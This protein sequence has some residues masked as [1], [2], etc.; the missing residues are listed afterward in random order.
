MKYWQSSAIHLRQ[1]KMAENSLTTLTF[2]NTHL[3]ETFILIVSVVGRIMSGSDF[4][5]ILNF[6]K[7]EISQDLMVN[8]YFK[9]NH[10]HSSIGSLNIIGLFIL[11]SVRA[12]LLRL[13]AHFF[14][15]FR[16]AILS[17]SQYIIAWQHKNIWETQFSLNR[18]SMVHF[19]HI[20]FS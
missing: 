15:W 1:F 8:K 5:V 6:G 17:A 13:T 16:K 10:T 19:C 20:C 2:V 7:T 9:E 11:V 12:E 4:R 18:L 3:A 14:K